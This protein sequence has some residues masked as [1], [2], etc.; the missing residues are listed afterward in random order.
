[1]DESIW[2][3]FYTGAKE[4]GVSLTPREIELFRAYL[5]ELKRWNS[6]INITALFDDIDI[7]IKHFVDSLTPLKYIPDDSSLLDI[8]SGGG[9]PGIPLKIAS[10][11]LYV[12]LLDSRLK[13]ANFQKHTIRTLQLNRIKSVIGRAEDKDMLESMGLSFDVVISRG[14]SNLEKFCTTGIPYVKKDGLL[15]AMRGRM[16]KMELARNKETLSRL[17]LRV[18]NTVELHLPYLNEKRGLLILSKQAKFQPSL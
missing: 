10:P 1:M 7:L 12:T 11:S 16:A 5:T 13:R 9:F 14:V 18:I 17:K 4:V 15:I 8:G 3:V 6:K 2:E